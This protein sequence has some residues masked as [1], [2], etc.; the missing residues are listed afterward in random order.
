MVQ[1][2][3]K[4]HKKCCC[5]RCWLEPSLLQCRENSSKH[6]QHP[7]H[8]LLSHKVISPSNPSLFHMTSKTFPQLPHWLHSVTQTVSSS[9]DHMNMKQDKRRKRDTTLQRASL[10]SATH[11]HQWRALTSNSCSSARERHQGKQ[12]TTPRL[13]ILCESSNNSSTMVALNKR[14]FWYTN[15]LLSNKTLFVHASLKMFS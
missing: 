6:V 9:Y 12:N 5:F 7:R 8:T 11:C 13:W 1:I 15:Q 4:F 2:A 10:C 3:W 14:Y